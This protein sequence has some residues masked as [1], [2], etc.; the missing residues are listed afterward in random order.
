[1]DNN[2]T[3]DKLQFGMPGDCGDYDDEGDEIDES[4]AIPTAGRR[5][6]VTT[7][8]ERFVL[9]TGD[10]EWYESDNGDNADAAKQG[11]ASQADGR[12]TQTL[13]DWGYSTR[14]CEDWTVYL[15][16]VK[17]DDGDANA[18]ASDVSEVK[19]VL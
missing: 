16:L 6:R 18:M 5:R 8:L 17:Y 10:V 4:D 3:D 13:D 19:T 9:G 15:R 12:L 2:C 11:D 14:E 1:M 7:E